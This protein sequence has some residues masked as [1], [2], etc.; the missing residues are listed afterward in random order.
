MIWTNVRTIEWPQLDLHKSC[1]A[2]IILRCY[3]RIVHASYRKQSMSIMLRN[4][5]R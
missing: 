3:Y 5:I 1:T 2:Y 4:H